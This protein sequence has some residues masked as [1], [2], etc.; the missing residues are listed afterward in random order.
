MQRDCDNCKN[1]L[2][3]HSDTCPHCGWPGIYPNVRD[4]EHSTEK[5][6]LLDRYREQLARAR[7][8]GCDGALA[9]FEK[10]VGRSNAV[11]VKRL[12]QTFSLAES[13]KNLVAT[14]GS[15]IQAG[16]RL[17][18]ENGWDVLR[19]VAE[20]ILFPHYGNKIHYAALSLDGVG[21]LGPYGECSI[22]LKEQMIIARATVFDGNSAS[23]LKNGS[24]LPG[25]RA[26]WPERPKLAVAKLG[27]QI[28]ADTRA[29]EYPQI[30]LRQGEPGADESFVE[31]HVYGPM[32][33]RT[34]ERVVVRM[35]NLSEAQRAL[36]EVLREY[37]ERYNVP[38]EKK[39]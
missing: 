15:Q 27:E 33:V 1:V 28:I 23:H 21:V 34:F 22:T 13:D 39:Q 31:V 24:P 18:D 38:L 9:D 2:P 11:M 7:S 5:Q 10:A 35:A 17:P 16:I 20:A 29:D 19:A 12:S 3:R 8:R 26:L 25:S 37:L 30:L 4:A 32:S 14:Y 6:A 36:V